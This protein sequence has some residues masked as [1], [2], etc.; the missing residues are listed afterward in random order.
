[1][2][3]SLSAYKCNPTKR[4]CA[5]VDSRILLMPA[6][7]VLHSVMHMLIKLVL[8]DIVPLVGERIKSQYCHCPVSIVT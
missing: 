3:F 5:D 4:T 1:M 6:A 2:R 8:I 7:L